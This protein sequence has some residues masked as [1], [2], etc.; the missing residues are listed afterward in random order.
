M[1][2]RKFEIDRAQLYAVQVLGPFG[3]KCLNC[4]IH[5]TTKGMRE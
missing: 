2:L 5:D 1:A 3:R 4:K